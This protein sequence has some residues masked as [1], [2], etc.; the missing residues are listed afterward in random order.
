MRVEHDQE[1]LE[2][3]DYC[4]GVNSLVKE[5]GQTQKVI[6]VARKRCEPSRMKLESPKAKT[7]AEDEVRA[8]LESFEE[9]GAPESLSRRQTRW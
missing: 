5:L 8:R 4:E 7:G 2:R 6:K 1:R 3:V 9:A